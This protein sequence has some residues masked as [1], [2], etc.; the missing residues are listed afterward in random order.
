MCITENF[1]TR[2]SGI[3]LPQNLFA[4]GFP[5]SCQRSKWLSTFLLPFV[6]N[7]AVSHKIISRD[8]KQSTNDKICKHIVHSHFDGCRLDLNSLLFS[9]C[10]RIATAIKKGRAIGVGDYKEY[11]NAEFGDVRLSKR[12]V[13]ILEQLSCDPTASISAACRDPYQAKAAYRFT[14]NDEVTVDA[15]SKITRDI[16]IESIV[17][18]KPSVVLIPQDTTKLDYTNLR[19]TKGLGVI[20]S[21]KALKGLKVHS[22]IAI[23]ESGETYGLLAQKIWVRPHELF[24]RKVDRRE[25]PIEEKESFRWLE[26]MM[27]AQAA[28]PDDIYAV[29]ICDREGDILE[30]FCKA[31]EMN[32]NILCRKQY[33]RIAEDDG[34]TTRLN[35]YIAGQ[36]ECGRITVKVPRDSHTNRKSRDAILA[37]KFG[38]CTLKRPRN[39]EKNDSV[40]KTIDM[41]FVSA[42][43]IG[44]V[45]EGQDKIYWQLLT[46]VPTESFEDAVTRVQWYTQRWKIELFHRTLKDGCKVE[47]LQSETAEKLMKLV[48]IYSII[49]LQIMLF[50]YAARA[51]PDESC[52]SYL[53]ESEW[54]ILYRVANKTKR[55][56]D[57]PPTIYE[58]VVMIAR[59][60]GFLARKSDGFPGVTV[61]W[62]GLTSFYTILDAVP[63]LA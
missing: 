61:I 57:K 21:S 60:G 52:E 23:G 47:E 20:G 25:M 13:R 31:I 35:D 16:T 43:E 32:A 40:P 2:F 53:A 58:A 62:R 4:S 45:P 27:A 17:A 38:K 12:M 39:L 18:D 63:F 9:R 50:T 41:Y 48:A 5:H 24:G 54:K 3:A 6:H 15:I 26:T 8:E 56:P 30:L 49:A 33:N 37:I 44:D 14:A 46:N 34:E 59:L 19:E 22:A 51:R 7:S 36:P 55:V 28:L 42:D 29:H 10:G 1:L 11:S